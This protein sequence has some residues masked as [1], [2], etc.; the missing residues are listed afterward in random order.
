MQSFR[1]LPTVEQINTKKFLEQMKVIEP[2]LFIFYRACLEI[3]LTPLVAEKV[4]REIENICLGS[5]FGKV[6]IHLQDS[7]I[8]DILGER[9]HKINEEV[10][11]EQGL[12]VSTDFISIEKKS[13]V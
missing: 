8:S 3:N 1:S 12:Y 13:E 9:R 10:N 11:T 7:K 5:G 6:I 2:A 4:Y